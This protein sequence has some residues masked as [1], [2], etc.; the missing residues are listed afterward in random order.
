MYN[1]GITILCHIIGLSEIDNKKYFKIRFDEFISKLHSIDKDID[2][3]IKFSYND[4]NE[5]FFEYVNENEKDAKYLDP[6]IVKE[7]VLECECMRVVVNTMLT[8]SLISIFEGFIAIVYKSL[9]MNAPIKYFENAQIGISR[10]IEED[11]KTIVDKEVS[12]LVTKNMSEPFNVIKSIES[13]EQVKIFNDS[14]L[15]DKVSE[16]NLIRNLYAHNN[17]NIDE[18]YISKS[19]NK[20]KLKLKSGEKIRFNITEAMT[21]IETMYM[22]IFIIYYSIV[23]A[24]YNGNLEWHEHLHN[25]IF[26]LLQVKEYKICEFMYKIMSANKNFEFKDKLIYKINYLISLKEQ[27]KKKDLNDELKMLD[28]SAVETRFKI[29]KKCLENK[30]QEVYEDL[31]E[32]FPNSFDAKS[33]K[34]FPLFISFRNSEYYSML[35]G[36]FK[37][38]FNVQQYD[39]NDMQEI[40]LETLEEK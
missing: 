34:T 21:M 29:A 24:Q 32:S 5:L 35:V 9:I 6:N 7:V 1:K 25:Q 8:T 26:K 30:N 13:K 39:N 4:K 19:K 2:S 27:N 23:N 17:G 28:V 15:L 33:I 37:K 22:A 12:N 31:I 18:I 3:K 14:D 36:K 11:I 20:H 38:E 40:N 10:I 16:I